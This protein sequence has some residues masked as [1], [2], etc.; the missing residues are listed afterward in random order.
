MGGLSDERILKK[1]RSLALT[2]SEKQF[3]RSSYHLL[4]AYVFASFQNV[5][6]VG[7]TILPILQMEN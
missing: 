3:P 4:S 7:S 2:E 6:Q 5:Y 1:R